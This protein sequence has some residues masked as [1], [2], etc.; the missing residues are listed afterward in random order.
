MSIEVQ[1]A[2]SLSTNS[3]SASTSASDSIP[4]TSRRHTTRSVA[5]RRCLRTKG[6]GAALE[7]GEG[8]CQVVV[9]FPRPERGVMLPLRKALTCHIRKTNLGRRRRKFYGSLSRPWDV[10][11]Q[12]TVK[13]KMRG[14]QLQIQCYMF[15]RHILNE[16]H[17]A[18][19]ITASPCHCSTRPL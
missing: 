16:I 5:M 14:I 18:W 12:N 15:N 19:S 7:D 3:M 2:N 6:C 1:R 9:R 8:G 13:T 17:N 4:D 11:L 10:F